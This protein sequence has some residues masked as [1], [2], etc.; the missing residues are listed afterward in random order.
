MYAMC[1]VGVQKKAACHFECDQ[2]FCL[3]SVVHGRFALSLQRLRVR[4]SQTPNLT[5]GF[6]ATVAIYKHDH[7]SAE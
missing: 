4:Q 3:A 7:I 2:N 1:Y 5:L 6:A